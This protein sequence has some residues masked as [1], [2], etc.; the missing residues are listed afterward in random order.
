MLGNVVARLAEGRKWAW[1]PFRNSK[2]TRLLQNAL[3]GNARAVFIATIH[4][5]V[6]HAEETASTLRFSSRAMQVES[7][8]H[9]NEQLSRS[10]RLQAMSKD[11]EASMGPL[12]AR[13]IAE[14]QQQAL[15]MQSEVCHVI[16]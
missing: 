3:G 7:A 12:Q 16:F 15:Q 14:L 8:Y 9:V 6:A 11:A 13:K 10:Q 2:L 5:G 4:L 1:L